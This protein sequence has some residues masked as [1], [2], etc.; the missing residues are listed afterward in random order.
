MTTSYI[1]RLGFA[2]E[3]GVKSPCKVSTIS[4]ITLSGEQVIDSISCVEGDRVMVRNQTDPTE[5]AIYVVNIGTWLRASDFNDTQDVINGMLVLDANANAVYRVEISGSY[6]PGVTPVT[7]TF[8]SGLELPPQTGHTGKFLRTDGVNSYWDFVPDEI[9]A[10]GGHAGEFLTTDGVN[11]SWG[12]VAVANYW[13]LSGADLYNNSGT[14]VGINNSA[15][16]VAFDVIVDTTRQSKIKLMEG[17][18]TDGETNR[19]FPELRLQHYTN[20]EVYGGYISFYNATPFEM[21]RWLVKHQDNAVETEDAGWIFYAAVAGTLQ[22]VWEVDWQDLGWQAFYDEQEN[23]WMAQ[24]ISPAYVSIGQTWGSSVGI[25]STH[26]G[27]GYETDYGGTVNITK[28]GL[29]GSDPVKTNAD[30]LV[31]TDANNVGISFRSQSTASIM[32]GD[33]TDSDIGR[34]QYDHADNSLSFWTNNLQAAR[35]YSNQGITVGSPTGGSQGSG[36]VNAEGLYI[37]G[38]LVGGGGSV[39]SVNGAD[40]YFNTGNVGIG[41]NA[42]IYNL[43]ISDPGVVQAYSHFTNQTTG[44]TGID[45]TVIGIDAAGNTNIYNLELLDM[46][47]GVNNQTMMRLHSNGDFSYYGTGARFTLNRP[48]LSVDE[49][50]TR[51]RIQPGDASPAG[52]SNALLDIYRS[53]NADTH[54]FI[55]NS[56]TGHTA[57][58][59]FHIGVDA[60]GNAEISNRTNSN[61]KFEVNNV[62]RMVLT[63]GGDLQLY[64]G[65]TVR[66]VWDFSTPA[67]WDQSAM[68]VRYAVDGGLHPTEVQIDTA[69]PNTGWR[70]VGPT[71][72]GA[73][74]IWNAMDNIPTDARSVRVRL[75]GLLQS[76]INISYMWLY[77]T[78]GDSVA[79]ID[80]GGDNLAFHMRTPAGAVNRAADVTEATI[81]LSSTGNR[82]IRLWFAYSGPPLV[83]QLS[84]RLLE[85]S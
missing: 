23:V 38:V 28:S 5:N 46:Y 60:S 36:T 67:N 52:S 40:I 21:A 31:L 42:P 65:A 55:G 12:S 79:A 11:L 29:S 15:P 17:F 45:G 61:L 80:T 83:N 81:P 6:N 51:V 20:S 3:E 70:T 59:G 27:M 32:F 73:Q 33:T 49:S 18:W 53:S 43:H 10:Q 7:F 56:N 35:I 41:I 37:N 84:M 85:W 54:L 57:S 63:N 19:Y 78:A 34:I 24:Y 71:G 69:L 72:S 9:P 48:I 1:S 50:V 75:N 68:P 25:A 13:T 74:V 44:H 58:L 39:W 64:D 8:T 76:D 62:T 77:A 30:T 47:L 4:N 2:P 16:D 26:I 82:H 66:T 14:Q 22:K